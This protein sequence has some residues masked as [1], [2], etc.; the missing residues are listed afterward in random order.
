MYYTI[1]E[2]KQHNTRNDC[3]VIVDK[4][5]YN[6][7]DFIHK[8]PGGPVFVRSN[9]DISEDFYDIGHSKRAEELLQEFYIGDL[10]TEAERKRRTTSEFFILIFMLVALAVIIF[11]DGARNRNRDYDWETSNRVHEQVMMFGL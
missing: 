7:T 9:K 3:W 5:V 6:I 10:E 8:H 11:Y 2:V 4:K 1:E